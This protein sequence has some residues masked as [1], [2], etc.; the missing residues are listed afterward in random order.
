[1][2]YQGFVFTNYFVTVKP[3]LIGNRVTFFRV[4]WK[5]NKWITSGFS[6]F[7]KP[8]AIENYHH[9]DVTFVFITDRRIQKVF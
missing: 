5:E 7:A 8:K 2:H 1:M 6:L 9:F 3:M 4:A